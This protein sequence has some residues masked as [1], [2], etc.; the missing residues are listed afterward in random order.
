MKKLKR[1]ETNKEYNH[2]LKNYKCYCMICNKRAGIYN[3]YCGP[4]SEKKN[5]N[6][7]QYRKTKWK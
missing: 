5:K 6:W 7:K 2:A 3:A 4:K 1:A